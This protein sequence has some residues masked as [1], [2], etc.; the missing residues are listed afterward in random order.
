MSAGDYAF[1]IS[2]DADNKTIT[3]YNFNF[4]A[5]EII[6]N[7]NNV[8]LSKETNLNI[9]LKQ[10]RITIAIDGIIVVES[11]NL[12]HANNQGDEL[13][14]YEVIKELMIFEEIEGISIEKSIS[15]I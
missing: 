14:Y 11:V 15:D 10:S 7:I 13:R 12:S 3:V 9:H 2:Y 5:G 4:D 1:S 6:K 8:D